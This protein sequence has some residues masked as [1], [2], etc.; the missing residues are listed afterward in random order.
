M[1]F[2]SKTHD[3]LGIIHIFTVFEDLQIDIKPE[4]LP[5]ILTN[6]PIC[7]ALEIEKNSI[8]MVEGILYLVF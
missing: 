4:H 7:V 2:Y 3:E 8:V 5:K 6:D 1:S